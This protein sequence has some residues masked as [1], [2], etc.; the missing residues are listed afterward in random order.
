MGNIYKSFI[1]KLEHTIAILDNV[2]LNT[3]AAE[4]HILIIIFTF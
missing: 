3:T 2:A 4:S 1:Q